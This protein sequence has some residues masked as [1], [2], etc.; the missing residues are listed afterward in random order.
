MV[1]VSVNN[2][3]LE[4]WFDSLQTHEVDCVAFYT[5]I[6]IEKTV[7]KDLKERVWFSEGKDLNEWII[8]DYVN[9][10]AHVFLEEKREFYS[11][12][13]LWGDGRQIQIE[14]KPEKVI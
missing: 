3:R 2:P 14:S 4:Y 8:L 10:I 13:L 7:L 11:L 9:V 1:L 12:E 5:T 6:E